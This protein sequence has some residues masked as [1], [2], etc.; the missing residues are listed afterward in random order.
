MLIRFEEN[1]EV[2]STMFRTQLG[3]MP[4]FRGSPMTGGSFWG[5]IIGFAKG[6]F[7]KAS[8]HISNIINQAQPHIKTVASKALDS[9]IDN[10]VDHVTAK[11]KKAQTGN[12]IKGR[13]RRIVPIKK[14]KKLRKPP[15]KRLQEPK[16][17]NSLL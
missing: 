12:G 8:P 6:L 14:V 13:K 2:F 4:K 7:S 15:R 16:L 10:A 17:Q 11:L 1:E 5:R 9:A 3:G